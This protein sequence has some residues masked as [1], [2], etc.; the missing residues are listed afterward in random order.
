MSKCRD[1]LVICLILATFLLSVANAA[2]AGSEQSPWLGLAGGVL[3]LEGDEAVES[4]AM[5]RL[6]L[7][8]EFTE[9]WS[10]ECSMMMVPTLDVRYRNSFGEKIPRAEFDET[11]AFGLS[12]DGLYH[13]HRAERFDPFLALGLGFLQFEEAPGSDEFNPSVRVGAGIQYH[14]SDSWAIRAEGR[15]FLAG[16]DT[17]VNSTLDIGIVWRREPYSYGKVITGDLDSDGDGVTD[18]EEARRGTDP[19]SAD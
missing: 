15:A 8:Y 3:T 1:S 9:A 10:L 14:F 12:L 18:K 16:T 13:F 6:S 4:S 2:Q 19:Y 5:V 11:S 7:G 17:E